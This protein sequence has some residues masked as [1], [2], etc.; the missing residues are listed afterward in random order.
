M[1][2]FFLF[3][4]ITR[5]GLRFFLLYTKFVDLLRAEEE[6][7]SRVDVARYSSWLHANVSVV[8]R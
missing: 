3:S 5:V 8:R 1:Y 2:D 4:S 6:E 7:R